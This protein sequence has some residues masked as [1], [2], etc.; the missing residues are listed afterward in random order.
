MRRSR[1]QRIRINGR[2][3]NIGL[4][5]H[6]VVK[7]SMAREKALEN[8]RVAYLAGDAKCDRLTMVNQRP[9][10]NWTAASV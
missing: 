10:G 8:R 6:P 4:G 3:T 9:V 2:E 5:P 1:V 7:L